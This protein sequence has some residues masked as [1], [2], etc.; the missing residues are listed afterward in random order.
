MF[1]RLVDAGVPC[2]HLVGAPECW[3]GPRAGW[4][5]LLVGW[6]ARVTGV[7]LTEEESTQY[8]A[9]FDQKHEPGTSPS[10]LC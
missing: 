9:R 4:A 7:M 2:K 10:N 8:A 6:G 5:R 1:H 3:L